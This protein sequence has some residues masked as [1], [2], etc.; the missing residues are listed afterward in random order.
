MRKSLSGT[1][2]KGGLHIVV[3]ND[4][5]RFGLIELM[6]YICGAGGINSLEYKFNLKF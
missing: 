6:L 5:N 1:F 2:L 4:D 3:R